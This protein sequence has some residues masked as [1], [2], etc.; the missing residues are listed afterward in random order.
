MF[1]LRD[2]ILHSCHA[3]LPRSFS[4]YSVGRRILQMDPLE[5]RNCFVRWQ[6]RQID[7][8]AGGEGREVDGAEDLVSGLGGSRKTCLDADSSSR[9]V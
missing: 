7:E 9:S 8:M 1:V 3:W 5:D 4:R 2:H 6:K